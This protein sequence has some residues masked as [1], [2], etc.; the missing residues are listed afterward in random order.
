MDRLWLLKGG[1]DAPGWGK[2]QA[3][4]MSKKVNVLH[5]DRDKWALV[6]AGDPPTSYEG[7]VPADPPD[8]LYL[9]N[10]GRPCYVSGHREVHSARV[11]ARA[12]G[13][14]AVG[15]LDKLGDADLV[16]ERLGRVY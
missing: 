15:L 11:V 13:D 1:P 8:G 9:D 10:H 14:E 3:D 6:K 5:F 7:L 16:L 12:L 4:A 2:L